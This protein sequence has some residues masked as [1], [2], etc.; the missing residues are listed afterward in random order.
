MSPRLIAYAVVGLVAAGFL[1][2]LVA[3]VKK[4]ERVDAAEAAAKQAVA[5]LDN[6]R[7]RVEEQARKDAEQLER[8]RRRDQVLTSTLAALQDDNE[9]LRRAVSRLASTVEKPDANG[10]PR[11]AI[12]PDW[13]LCAV[14]APLG[15]DPADIAACET[16]AGDGGVSNPERH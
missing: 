2:W 6:Y 1:W 14:S 13:M 10:V 7:A 3:T 12:N 8:D 9:A 15:R 4:A 16:R 11:L 5:N